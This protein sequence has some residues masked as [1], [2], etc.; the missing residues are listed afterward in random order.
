MVNYP[1]H[2]ER[3]ITMKTLTIFSDKSISLKKEAAVPTKGATALFLSTKLD[4]ERKWVGELIIS[5]SVA[6]SLSLPKNGKF[7]S[8]LV[9]QPLAFVVIAEG[10]KGPSR[11]ERAAT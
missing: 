9:K 5:E 10:R 11:K 7:F 8:N 4:V 3:I 2:L 1:Y 6:R